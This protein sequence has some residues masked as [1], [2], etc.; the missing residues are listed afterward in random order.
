MAGAPATSAPAPGS[1]FDVPGVPGGSTQW[2]EQYESTF[3]LSTTLSPSVQVQVNGIQIFKQVDVVLDWIWECE[4][5]SLSFTAGTGQTLTNSAYA[6]ANFVGPVQLLI[7]NQY[8]SVDVESGID[9]YIFNLIRP[10]TKSNRYAAMYA[11]VQGDRIGDSST[12]QGYLAAALA[13]PLLIN[14]ALWTRASTAEAMLFRLPASMY[15][16]EYFDLAVTGEP[17]VGPLETYVSPQYMAGTTRVITPT[18]KMN[19]LLGATTDIAPVQTTALTPTTDTASTA[20]GTL[21]S[22][23]RR[24]SIYAG[25]PATLPPVY[26]WQYRW[27][28]TRFGIS[29][30]AIADLLVPLDTG[31]LMSIYIRLFDPLASSGVGAP[32]SLGVIKRANLQY[33]SGLL[34]FDDQNPSGGIYETQRKFIDQHGVVLPAGVFAYDLALDEH[35]NIS[36]RRCLNTL[37]T[38]G[39]EV[40]VEFTSAQ[41]AAAYAVMGCESLVYVT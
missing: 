30:L 21:A 36:N 15:F 8:A 13:Q 40:H 11:N 28:T 23:F 33:G 25:N 37:T 22:T 41:S 9:L 31:Q 35:D 24:R 17:I 7:Q 14:T 29:G 39:I 2:S 34:Y 16:D 26:A 3:G 27:K 6:P 1:L 12:G 20:T 19:P 32:I 18:V 4:L 10:L 38:A 5:S